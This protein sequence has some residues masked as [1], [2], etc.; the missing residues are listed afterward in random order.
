MWIA[1]SKLKYNPVT[2]FIEAG[3]QDVKNSL[4]IIPTNDRG[5][6]VEERDTFDRMQINAKHL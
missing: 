4:G 3:A 2:E 1:K 6:E 5:S